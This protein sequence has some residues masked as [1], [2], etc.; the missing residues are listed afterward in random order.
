MFNKLNTTS[1]VLILLFV[2]VSSWLYQRDGN[3][4]Q[5]PVEQGLSDA[6][7]LV[8]TDDYEVLDGCSLIK[9]RRNDADSF[10][11]KHPEGKTEFRL[12]YVDAPESRY[13]EYANGDTNGKRIHA[14]GKYFG[15]LKREAATALGAKG[16]RFV[17]DLLASK[18]FRVITRWEH[19]FSPERRY[20]FV[21]IEHHGK[22]VFLHE[23]LIEMGYARIHT[24]PAT[25]PDGGNIKL[26]LK[27]LRLLEK[28][29]KN[30]KLGGWR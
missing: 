1:W 6:S 4:Y 14:Q 27:K 9:N 29:A 15:G 23:L 8:V 11:V 3:L 13:R 10:F 19:V 7:E 30:A 20:A 17:A 2:A 22:Q 16:K 24:K 26:Q 25:M 21:V 5:I 28:S 18:P 12:Y